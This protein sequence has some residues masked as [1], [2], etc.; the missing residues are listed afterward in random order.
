MVFTTDV[1]TMN[2]VQANNVSSRNTVNVQMA[3]LDSMVGEESPAMLKIDVEGFESPTLKGA[4]KTLSKDS[5][6]SVIMELNG[7]GE[8]YGFNESDILE[9]ML[10]HG[11]KTYSYDPLK[12]S[13]TNL[14]G[15][16][17]VVGNTLFVKNEPLVMERCENAPHFRV[18]GI[19]I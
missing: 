15:K 3:T 9:S 12:R 10:G 7:S 2:H 14:E 16:N 6:H 4:K 1:D 17:L 19:S 11:F 8:R 5:L 13:L 18:N